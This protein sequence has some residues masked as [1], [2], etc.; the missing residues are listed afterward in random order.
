V[1]TVFKPPGGNE[2]ADGGLLDVTRLSISA[3]RDELDESSLDTALARIL[4]TDEASV[5][6]HGFSNSI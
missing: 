2:P 1:D 4:A 3:L 5:G 6:H